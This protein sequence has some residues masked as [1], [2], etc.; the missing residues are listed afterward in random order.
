MPRGLLVL[1]LLVASSSRAAIAPDQTSTMGF[2][3]SRAPADDRAPEPDARPEGAEPLA[4]EAS[5]SGSDGGGTTPQLRVGETMAFEELGP[6]IVN[7]DGSTR[8][9]TNWDQMTPAEQVRASA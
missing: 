4:I 5:G 6:I 1:V 2:G 3:A 8:R 9:I 7:S